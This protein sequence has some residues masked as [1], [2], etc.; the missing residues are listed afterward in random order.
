[1]TALR[2]SHGELRGFAKVTRDLSEAKRLESLQEQGRNLTE[3]LAI[4][5]HELRNPLAPLRNALSVMSMT[6]ELPPSIAWSH[7]VMDRQLSQLT[8]I[9][10]DL[11]DVSRVTQGKLRLR[12]EPMDLN[13]AAYRAIEAARP[14]FD[15]RRQTLETKLSAQ[16]L[17]LHGDLARLTQVIVNLL[18]N[19]AKYT[20]EGGRIEI[21]TFIEGDLGVLRVCDNGI[22]ISP[23]HMHQIF[24]LF[25]QGGRS[26]D[27]A[28][29]G[30]GIGLTLAR[31][32]VEMHGGALS[33]RSPGVG[34]GSEFDVRLP[35]LEQRPAGSP[36]P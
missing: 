4:L 12:N 18:N 36:P 28:A 6:G 7:G 2:D 22:G 19:A 31:R 16:A 35:L 15:E 24:E 11:L 3:F 21:A 14:L 8:R 27:R 17:W 25:A 32:I 5:A 30:L 10:D 23:D 13:D 9:V 34:Q 1:V 29:G 20:Q 33:G 26:L